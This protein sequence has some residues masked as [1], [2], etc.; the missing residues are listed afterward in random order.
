MIVENI[1]LLQCASGIVTRNGRFFENPFNLSSLDIAILQDK[2][3]SDELYNIVGKIDMPIFTVEHVTYTN[4]VRFD[5]I[6]KFDPY[7]LKIGLAISSILRKIKDTGQSELFMW[8]RSHEDYDVIC[9]LDCEEMVNCIAQNAI[10]LKPVY[11][12]EDL[13]NGCWDNDTR[14]SN[15][16][17]V[18]YLQQR[19][20][21][22]RAS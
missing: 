21:H 3:L 1:S 12:F 18:N 19:Y 10:I 5:K 16:A 6:A 2:K 15:L 7:L 14:F 17:M 9:D 11:S 13:L 4:P 8:M 20:K 22:W